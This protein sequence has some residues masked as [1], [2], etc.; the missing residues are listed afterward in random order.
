MKIKY[1]WLWRLG[2]VLLIGALVNRFLGT[3]SSVL[4]IL[5]ILCLVFILISRIKTSQDGQPPPRIQVNAV[6]LPR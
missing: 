3:D 1:P 5:S 2:L 4:L 6:A